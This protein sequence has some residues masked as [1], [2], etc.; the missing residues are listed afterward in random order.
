MKRREKGFSRYRMDSGQHSRLLL[1]AALLGVSSD[2]RAFRRALAA[3]LVVTL[4]WD[5]ALGKPADI[6]GAAIGTMANA[7]VFTWQ[8]M[9]LRRYRTQ[10]LTVWKYH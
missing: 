10:R 8:T 5:Y 6:D 3:G 1:V 9:R 7:A 4:V 2:G